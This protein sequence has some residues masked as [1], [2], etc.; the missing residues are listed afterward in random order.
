MVGR[1]ARAS[2]SLVS[3]L[4]FRYCG[5]SQSDSESRSGMDPGSESSAWLLFFGLAFLVHSAAGVCSALAL[6]SVLKGKTQ[7]AGESGKDE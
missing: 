3:S 5:A 7:E 2:G 4:L 1:V 6:R